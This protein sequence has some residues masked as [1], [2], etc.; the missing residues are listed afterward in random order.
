MYTF[1]PKS[2]LLDDAFASATAA[3]TPLLEWDGNDSAATRG[4]EKNAGIR[5]AIVATELKASRGIRPRCHLNISIMTLLPM[6]RLDCCQRRC[7]SLRTRTGPMRFVALPTI[8]ELEARMRRRVKRA[9][10]LR[11]RPLG[12][13]GLQTRFGGED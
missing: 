5:A 2:G 12:S 1:A 11:V 6:V 3:M 9:E 7:K 4:S 10:Q 8:D 13:A